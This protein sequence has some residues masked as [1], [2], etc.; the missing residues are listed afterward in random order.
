[1]K[2]KKEIVKFDNGKRKWRKLFTTRRCPD[3]KGKLENVIAFRE[4]P[5][6][7]CRDCYQEVELS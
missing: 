6:G 5:I 4:V 3:C 1:M 7:F 2:E